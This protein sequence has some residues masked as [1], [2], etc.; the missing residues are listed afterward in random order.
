MSNDNYEILVLDEEHQ[1]IIVEEDCR[2]LKPIMSD[3]MQ[4]YVNNSNVP[5]EEWLPNKLHEHLPERSRDEIVRM[6]DEI[7]TA[8]RISEEKKISLKKAIANGRSKESW[9]ASEMKK[10]TSA[11]SAQQ[12]SEYLHGLDVAVNTANDSLHRTITTMAGNVSNNPCLDG[13]IAEQYH[14]Q[15]FN[16]N[17][18]AAGSPY[19]AE[20]LEP[21]GAG[22]KKNSVDIVIKDANGKVVKRYQS[23][24]C[25]D[26]AA[27]Q[28]AFEKG[29]Y[30]GQQ[31]L[32]PEE[33]LSSMTKKSTAVIES[34]DGVTSNPLKKSQAKQMQQEAQ[35]GKWNDLNWNEYKSKDLAIGV[36]KQ[37]GYAALQGAAIGVGF[38]IA[39]KIWN[40][41]EIKGEDVVETAITSGADFGVK[42]A[43]AGAL[44]VGAEKGVIRFIPKGTPAATIAN[45]AFVAIENVKILGKVATGKLTIKEG[46][47]KMGQTTVSVTAGL[48]ASAKGAAVGAAV[49]TVFGPVGTAVGGFVGGAVGYMAGSKVGEAVYNGAKKVA[50]KVVEAVKSVASNVKA[51]ASK[52]ATG[53]KNLF[54]KVFG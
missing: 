36:G 12:A 21:N 24:Y 19:R 54:S 3:F 15:T 47:E 2:E 10:A 26:A 9:F 5:V 42:A 13:F 34:P 53:V 20:V 6:S 29:D 23:K 30:R 39:K 48:A 32:V 41:E 16:M 11:M 4:A 44:K 28:K 51:T 8:V 40:G 14:A 18:E 35:S 45:I 49:G 7:I 52:V 27:T 17:A 37:A 50:G 46:L 22:Y 31:K 25:K 43:T 1:P 33:Q 38:D